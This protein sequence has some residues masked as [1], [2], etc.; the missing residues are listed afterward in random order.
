MRNNKYLLNMGTQNIDAFREEFTSEFSDSSMAVEDKMYRIIAEYK[1]QYN[2]ECLTEDEIVMLLG[3]SALFPN[4]YLPL[5]GKDYYDCIAISDY[6]LYL[7]GEGENIVEPAPRTLEQIKRLEETLKEI[8][9]FELLH[10]FYELGDVDQLS[11]MDQMYDA[12][13]EYHESIIDRYYGTCIHSYNEYIELGWNKAVESSLEIL[14]YQCNKYCPPIIGLSSIDTLC[15]TA[16]QVSGANSEKI[17]NPGALSNLKPDEKDND[18]VERD[19][20]DYE[21]VN[22]WRKVECDV[23]GD[24]WLLRDVLYEG[25]GVNDLEFTI[26]FDEF[27]IISTNME[28]YIEYKV[29]LRLACETEIPSLLGT[30][31]MIEYV[32]IIINY[33]RTVGDVYDHYK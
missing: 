5:W 10:G 18:L 30:T 9:E 23:S 6:E 8:A 32:H 31:K 17:D 11:E 3:E 2:I 1:E 25:M 28:S 4:L 13:A 24:M 27:M 26:Y 14:E 7:L 22:R 15:N 12:M 19:I 21:K 16:E 29:F 33:Y 20:Q